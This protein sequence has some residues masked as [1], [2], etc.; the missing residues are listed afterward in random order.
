MLDKVFFP[1]INE[2]GTNDDEA[3]TRVV[4]LFKSQNNVTKTFPKLLERS[5]KR[6]YSSSP[7]VRLQKCFED[8]GLPLDEP[9]RYF[10]GSYEYLFMN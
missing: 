4:G 9:S 3:F 5:V 1:Q 10:I 8:L 2:N 6:G 7:F